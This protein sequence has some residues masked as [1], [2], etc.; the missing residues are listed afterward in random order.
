MTT[1]VAS[2]PAAAIPARRRFTVAEYYAMADAG[3]LSENDRVELLDGD[4]IVMPPIG[5]WHAGGVKFFNNTML[6][7][8]LSRAMIAVQDPVRLDE[9]SEPQPDIMLL[10]WRDD[11][12]RSGHP[13]PADVLLLIEVADTSV[14]YDRNAKLPVYARAGI[15][16]V[17][18]VN[19]SARRVE[20]YSEPSGDTYSTVRHFIPG[21]TIA[22]QAFPNIVLA[23]D[24]IIGT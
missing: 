11:F 7:K 1:P 14:G 15:P 13:R 20:S 22:P 8:L 9:H 12:Y 24:P 10:Q 23:V 17:W 2:P 18:I 19:R 3:I 5:D 6:P 16:E 21:E 4:I